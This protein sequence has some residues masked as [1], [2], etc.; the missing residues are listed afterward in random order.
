MNKDCLFCKIINN[1]IKSYTIYEDDYVKAFL[2]AFPVSLGH[3]LIVPKKHYEN[4][5]DINE[6][7]LSKII[8]IAKKIALKYKEVFEINNLQLVHSAGKDG[9]Q[10]IFHFHLHL[11]PRHKDDGIN[12]VQKKSPELVEKYNEF[13]NNFKK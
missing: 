11:I 2:D 13:I 10:E 12:I 9:Q 4:I 8:K 1:E 6:E 5:Y 7:Y 3:V